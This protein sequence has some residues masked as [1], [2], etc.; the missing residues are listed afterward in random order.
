MCQDLGH[1]VDGRNKQIERK[2]YGKY[3]LFK[4]IMDLL[5]ENEIH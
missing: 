2:N 5:K 3:Y 4:G 1:I